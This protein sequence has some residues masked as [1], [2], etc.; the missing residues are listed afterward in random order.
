M[1]D[2]ASRGPMPSARCSM[3]RCTRPASKRTERGRGDG[4]VD[5]ADGEAVGVGV[6]DGETAEVGVVGAAGLVGDTVGGVGAGAS[7]AAVQPSNSKADSAKA[8]TARLIGRPYVA[9]MNARAACDPLE[10]RAP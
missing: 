5:G 8:R 7:G 3:S 2:V 6:G 10:D 9:P 4:V 1:R